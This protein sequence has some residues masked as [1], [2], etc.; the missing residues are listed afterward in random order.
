M[1]R[2]LGGIGVD[3]AENV[4][5]FLTYCRINTASKAIQAILPLQVIK[6]QLSGGSLGYEAA[7]DSVLLTCIITRVYVLHMY[8]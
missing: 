4:R 7:F 1:H 5:I 3:K 2:I 6:Q 8:L